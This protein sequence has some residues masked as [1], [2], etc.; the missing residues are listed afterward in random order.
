LKAGIDLVGTVEEDI[1]V[2][3]LVEGTVDLSTEVGN[4]FLVLAVVDYRKN[5]DTW[6]SWNAV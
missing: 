2:L 5:L 4:R 3:D 1:L 6:I